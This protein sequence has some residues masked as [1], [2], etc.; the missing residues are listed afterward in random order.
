MNFKIPA[1]VSAVF[2]VLIF[3]INIIVKNSILDIFMRSVISA[4]LVFGIVFGVIFVLV[5]IL[6]IDFSQAS[7]SAPPPPQQGAEVDYVIG[8]D[9][10]G[11]EIGE[12]QASNEEGQHEVIDIKPNID[13]NS[14]ESES[15]EE[16]YYE[17][18]MADSMSVDAAGET[19]KEKLGMDASAED[20]A[21][22]VKTVIKRDG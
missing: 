8:D 17:D 22:A 7:E 4:I 19:I 15:T 9:P 13:E 11:G 14:Y 10:I 6:K 12:S 1:I 21:K 20:L 3:I 2:F 16:E 18:D 5:D